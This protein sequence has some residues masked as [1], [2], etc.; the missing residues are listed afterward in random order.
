MVQELVTHFGPRRTRVQE[1]VNAPREP[2]AAVDLCF[3]VDVM[4]LGIKG[5][6][7]AHYIRY[8]DWP[9]YRTAMAPRSDGG[10][11]KSLMDAP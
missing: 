4:T 7:G 10:G 5:R 9:V 2:F 1:R 8:V 3:E 6:G 11:G